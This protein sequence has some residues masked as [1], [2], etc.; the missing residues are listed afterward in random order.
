MNTEDYAWI[1]LINHDDVR[2]N[3]VLITPLALYRKDIWE[4]I[5]VD[6]RNQQFPNNGKAVIFVQDF[7]PAKI[8]RLWQFYVRRLTQNGEF[9]KHSRYV[10]DGDLEPAN[11]AQVVNWTSRAR[12]TFDLPDLLEYGLAVTE[13]SCQ[14]IYIRF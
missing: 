4:Q 6:T 14:I 7:P 2:P 3:T 8:D 12:D 10:V 5:T 1:G 9:D 11:L 13:C